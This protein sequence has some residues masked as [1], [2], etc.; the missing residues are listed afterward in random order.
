MSEAPHLPDSSHATKGRAFF[1]LSLFIGVLAGITGG[2]FSVRAVVPGMLHD[3]IQGLPLSHTVRYDRPVAERISYAEM[4][5]VSHV[6]YDVNRQ[7][8]GVGIMFTSDGWLITDGTIA[9]RA[10]FLKQGLEFYEL[11]VDATIIDP[12]SEVGF[13]KIDK[14]SYETVST[15]DHSDFSIGD[16]LY[17]G[18][19]L[20]GVFS[21]RVSL[22]LGVRTNDTHYFEG[23]EHHRVL[24]LDREFSDQFVGS[25]VLTERGLLVGML[26]NDDVLGSVV[27]PVHHFASAFKELVLTGG[28]S[29]VDLGIRYIPSIYGVSGRDG[30]D[31]QE[32]GSGSTRI[33]AVLYN[34]LAYRAGLR[35]GDNI[36]SINGIL[37]GFDH[38][39]PEILNMLRDEDELMVVYR[40]GDFEQ[41]VTISI[42]VL[43][44]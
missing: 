11:S 18:H 5:Q 31:G 43:N 24:V 13:V 41:N 16:T 32:I 6:L 42:P 3:L 14:G 30:H 4:T 26:R 38:S 8:I 17:I 21:S 29:V 37:L 2:L 25:P 22:P 19:Q 27:V 40:R 9:K 33:P 39:L 28:I 20:S 44:E 34:S 23:Y 36:I 12:A 7:A 35:D 15:L 10:T 1:I